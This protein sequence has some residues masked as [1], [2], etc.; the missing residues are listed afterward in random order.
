MR[1]RNIVVTV[2]TLLYKKEVNP[3]KYSVLD[4]LLSFKS[5]TYEKHGIRL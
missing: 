5:S 3:M 1:V 2:V 4:V